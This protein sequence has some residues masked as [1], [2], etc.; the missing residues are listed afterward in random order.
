MF[1]HLIKATRCSLKGLSTLWRQETAFRLECLLLLM[2]V[3]ITPHI[4]V[5]KVEHL[6]LI[7][8]L[9]LILITEVI[10][11]AIE[12]IIDRIGKEQHVLSGQA[13]DMGSAAVFL[14][15]LLAILTW[16]SILWKF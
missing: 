14:A 5:S 11:S 4:D 15:I 7:A 13:K 3:L 12:K 6:L 16:T 2:G 1:S 9:I 8:S 10:N